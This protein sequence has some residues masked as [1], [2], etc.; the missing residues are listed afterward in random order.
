MHQ[1]FR[2]LKKTSAVTAWLS[3]PAI[4]FWVL[5][6]LMVLLVAGTIAQKYVGL[7]LAQKTFFSSFY[8]WCGPL[9]LPGGYTVTAFIFLSLLAKF[10]TDSRWS[11]PR[12][13]IILT[14]FGALILLAGGLLTAVT[15][16]EG[17]IMIDE[18]AES[19]QV[20]DYHARALMISE[21]EVE[22]VRVAAAAL[23][24]GRL[25]GLP[26]HLPFNVEILSS[27]VNGTPQPRKSA[28][29]HPVALRGAAEKWR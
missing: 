24:P 5:P 13:G 25:L 10:I 16:R 4:I 23:K 2:I 18:G 21:D 20:E 14:H 3:R 28:P 9:P 1:Y 19:A 29:K 6:W 8:F 12:A 11:W 26:E 7:Y 27:M 17:F 15:A 22:F